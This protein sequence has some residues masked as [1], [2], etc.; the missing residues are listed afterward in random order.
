MRGHLL[1]ARPRGAG[2]E[3]RRHCWMDDI[4]CVRASDAFHF[5]LLQRPIQNAQNS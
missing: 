5:I 1:R 2:T 4:S 3:W